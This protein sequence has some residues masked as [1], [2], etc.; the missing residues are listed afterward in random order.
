MDE[1]VTLAK[2]ARGDM[3]F[4]MGGQRNWGEGIP[5]SYEGLSSWVE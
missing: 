4:G 2:P 5:Q 1:T 3:G